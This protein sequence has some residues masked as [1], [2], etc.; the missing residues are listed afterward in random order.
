MKCRMCRI[1]F[2]VIEFITVENLNLMFTVLN[3]S[4][5]NFYL[6]LSYLSNVHEF[7]ELWNILNESD[8]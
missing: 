8:L 6:A 1:A 2:H 5:L 7:C 4:L 3:Q